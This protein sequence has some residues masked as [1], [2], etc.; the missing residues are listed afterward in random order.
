MSTK[1]L[2]DT[3]IKTVATAAKKY[4]DK[5]APRYLTCSTTASTGSKTITIASDSTFKL[6]SGMIFV[7]KFTYGNT[8]TT[9]TLN[10]N[11]TGAKSIY[12][13]SSSAY[14][15]DIAANEVVTFLYD[16][17][18]YR[19]IDIP[20]ASLNRA[21][22]VRLSNILT[23]TSTAMAL[24]AAQGKVLNDKIPAVET[25]TCTLY[26]SGHSSYTSTCNY[27]KIGKIV[28]LYGDF[29]YA[30]DVTS[31]NL[32]GIPFTPSDMYFGISGTTI[33]GSK[34][35]P[36]RMI[37][38][39]ANSKLFIR[40]YSPSDTTEAANYISDEWRKQSFSIVYCTTS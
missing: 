5:K 21:G 30:A 6:V 22:K 11:S 14:S 26:L 38:L 8:H 34:V 12:R 2:S 37:M 18:Y 17:T 28:V 23:S 4:T 7:V 3:N 32:L 29:P 40:S 39:T 27:V 31:Q 16:G 10:I 19:V 25:G 13:D 9:P 15:L 35:I 1:L 33:Y 24:T 20:N 36:S